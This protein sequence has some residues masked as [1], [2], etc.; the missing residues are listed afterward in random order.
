MNNI[1]ISDKKP[2]VIGRRGEN[3]VTT[4]RFSIDSL[5]PNIQNATYSLIHQ[6]HGDVAPYPVTT[7]DIGG[8]VNW[9]V[10]SGDLGKAGSGTAQLT[11]Y[12]DGAVAKS[13]IFTTIT[14]D[15][16]GMTDAPD[17]VQI[18][19]DRVIRAGQEAVNAASEAEESAEEAAAS[20]AAI[21][22]SVEQAAASARAAAA[23]AQGVADWASD[24]ED[25]ARA[26]AQSVSDAQQIA[27]NI[28]NVVETEL[29]AAKQSGEFDGPP[30]PSGYSPTV[31]VTAITGGHRITI[32]DKNG[33]HRFDVMDGEDGTGQDIYGGAD[34]PLVFPTGDTSGRVE[35]N[36]SDLGATPAVNDYVIG[37]YSS[38]VYVFKITS[39]QSGVASG[40]GAT[41]L[42]SSFS[43]SV[44]GSRTGVGISSWTDGTTFENY[45]V[46]KSEVPGATVGDFIIG[47]RNSELAVM[48]A[49]RENSTHLFGDGIVDLDTLPIPAPAS[50]G[51]PEMDGTAS[52]GSSSKYAR[53]DHRHPVTRL[54]IS[55]TITSL[56]KEITDP[57]ILST[58]RVI[59]CVFDTPTAIT[60]KLTWTTADGSLILAGTPMAG[61]TTAEIDLDIF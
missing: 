52:L 34:V 59:N 33:A 42:C 44:Y 4:I 23:S 29:A 11:A 39:I 55:T 50:S 28:P 27:N 25:S 24:A 22:D 7:M 6:R 60:S 58:M 54:H 19:I 1:I 3:N 37:S 38:G 36:I 40:S 49:V 51:T 15:S 8:Y 46:P 9:V 31:T 17:P 47:E 5:F 16:M 30:G 26:A 12:K 35:V 10:N 21:G 45:A 18:Y 56:P 32:T 2:I 57:R 13:I 61:S 53:A 14:L 48:K 43:P 41:K 20:V